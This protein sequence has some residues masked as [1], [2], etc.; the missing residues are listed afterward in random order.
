MHSEPRTDEGGRQYCVTN[1]EFHNVVNDN[2]ATCMAGCTYKTNNVVGACICLYTLILA[3][4]MKATFF[5]AQAPGC[6]LNFNIRCLI[7]GLDFL[8]QILQNNIRVTSRNVVLLRQTSYIKSK[9]SCLI[10][11]VDKKCCFRDS[12]K[13]EM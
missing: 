13:C 2:I 6:L 4:A 12:K 3:L 8:Y 7:I 1:N 9:T 5:V 11:S 10:N